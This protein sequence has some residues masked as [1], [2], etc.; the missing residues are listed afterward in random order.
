MDPDL[1]PANL[2]AQSKAL[3]L[4]FDGPVCNIFAG[5][6]PAQIASEMAAEFS[7]QVTTGDPLNVVR[8]AIRLNGPISAIH[9]Y[10]KAA[11]ID[12]IGSAHETP[13]IRHLVE[14][15]RGPIAIVSNNATEAIELWLEHVGLNALVTAVIGRDP[16]HMKPDPRSLTKAADALGVDIANC[17]F[18]GDS[19]SDIQ[20]AIV[21]QC[22]IIA[23]A[24]KPWKRAVFRSITDSPIVD[25]LRQ[26]ASTER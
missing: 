10:L 18:I 9:Q 14:T 2:V 20:A 22:P 12:A 23:F 5:S 7:M 3:L 17:V 19:L 26:L 21:A 15:Y 25:D 13:G 1:S 11:E 24:N 8:E 4:D 16:L 6:D